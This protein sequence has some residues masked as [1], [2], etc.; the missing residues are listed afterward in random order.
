MKQTFS[1][2][3]ISIAALS[4]A[5][6][7]LNPRVPNM[8]AKESVKPTAPIKATAPVDQGV[9][10]RLKDIARFRGVRSNQLLGTGLIMGLDGTGDTKNMGPTAAALANYLRRQNLDVD[11]KTLQAKN[12]ALVMVTAELPP[13]ATN[14]QKLD[15]TVTSIGDAKSL[16]NGT[17]LITELKSPVDNATVYATAAGPVS[18][19]GFGVSANGNS[20]TKGFLTVGR[21]PGGAQ[22]EKGAATNLIHDGN[23]MYLELDDPDATTAQRTQERINA[24]A[25]AYHALAINGST[26]EV[27][28]PEGVTPIAAMARLEEISVPTDQSALIIV[29]EKTGTIVMGGNIKIAPVA[30]MYGSLSI[31]VEEDKF[32]SQPA[33]FSNGDT[34][35]VKKNDVKGND[36]TVKTGV[37]TP[38]T[39][40]ADLAAIFQK[41]NLSAGDVIAI[42]QSLRQQGALKARVILQ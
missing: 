3:L 8:T 34:K 37:T 7:W 31:K 35:V 28:L 11:P 12:V 20:Q 33:P 41:L 6:G 4:N 32:V 9:V 42:L 18:V 26:I 14:G 2:L 17:L 15:V 16:R 21:I 30:F 22:V 13:F 36:D 10:A 40:V 24:Q 29:N 5:Q 38:N 23:K 27:T 25:P 19:G 39:T 1:L